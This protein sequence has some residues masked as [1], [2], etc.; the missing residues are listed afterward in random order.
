MSLE[1]NNPPA[2]KEG[3]AQ[4]VE[5]CE[6][7]LGKAISERPVEVKFIQEGPHAESL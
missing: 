4:A 6:F 1:T 5:L 3:T 2:E 7:L